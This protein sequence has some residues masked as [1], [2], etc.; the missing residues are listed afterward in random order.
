MS[1][2]QAYVDSLILNA[3][4]EGDDKP[5]NH[6]F[7]FY[8]NRLYRAGLR[9]CADGSLTEECIQDVFIDLWLYRQSLGTIL[10]LENYL[11]T[12]LRRRIFKK[13][14][15]IDSLSIS[16]NFDPEITP[17]VMSTES[18]ETIL[19]QQQ[20][21]DLSKQRLLNALETLT[22]KQ[23]DIIHLKYFEERSYQDI[24]D[25]TGV[26]MGSLYK[27][28]HDAIKKLKNILDNK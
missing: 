26:E 20:T 9:W 13:L 19:I 21:D 25:R 3:L 28:L 24:A 27:L 11:K 6:L 16:A 2:Y 22:P 4:K 8:Y 7:E 18:Y 23:R 5:L 14:K 10:S 17:S 12:S 15:Q 1:N